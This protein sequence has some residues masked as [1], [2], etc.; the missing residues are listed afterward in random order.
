VKKV[1]LVK[2]FLAIRIRDWWHAILPPVLSFYF[3]GLL[4]S[5]SSA[6]LLQIFTHFIS[7]AALAVPVA[8]FGFLINDWTDIEIDR[9]ANK[10]NYV[11]GVS[12][13]FR[14]LFLLLT[15]IPV[16][17][18]L[19]V[20]PYPNSVRTFTVLQML[21]LVLYSCPPI[22]WKDGL[23]SAIILDA[24][25]SSALP[26]VIAVLMS[27]GSLDI[28]VAILTILFGTAKGI[29][30]ILYHFQV[31]YKHDLAGGRRT[32]AHRFKPES[33]IRWQELL[34]MSEIVLML[35]ICS[36]A[37]THLAWATF[38]IV[39]SLVL[40]LRHYTRQNCEAQV[41]RQQWLSELNTLYEAWLPL[42]VLIALLVNRSIPAT[43]FSCLALLMMFPRT[44]IIFSETTLFL[45]NIAYLL[46]NAFYFFSDLYFI[47]VKP[48]WDLGRM[49]RTP[50]N[51]KTWSLKLK[52]KL[53]PQQRT[54]APS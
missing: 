23:Y 8:A 51:K 20:Y 17:A 33:I 29:R 35:K 28:E 19:I 37:N 3:L 44:R 54:S 52:P 47:R 5:H 21:L 42:F 22:R 53:K 48:R 1:A 31:D 46:Y 18:L 12:M 34:W 40:K 10:P 43:V 32:V 49:L 38:A 14:I 50:F 45:K 7:L 16:A 26:F 27:V 2:F 15:V 41:L 13:P 39:A 25:Y 24:M 30:N 6:G 36:L 11:G 9:L 4:L